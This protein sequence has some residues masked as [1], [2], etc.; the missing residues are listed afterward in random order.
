MST[1]DVNGDID[2]K[3]DAQGGLSSSI[4]SRVETA[5]VPQATISGGALVAVVAIMTFLASLAAGSVMLVRAAGNEWQAD[6]AREITIQIRPVAG[7]DI[8][9]EVIKAAIITRA[10]AGIAEVRPYSKEEATQLL[11]PWLGSGLQLDDLP[12][13]RR[14]AVRL[15]PGSSPAGAPL[16]QTPS[17]PLPRASPD[18][19][20]TILA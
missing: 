12:V 15:A 5:V 10:S 9:M 4:L 13:P 19:P 8:E 1:T 6:V 17:P 18:T 20:P 7:R 3:V 14:V 2:R 16:P 11:E